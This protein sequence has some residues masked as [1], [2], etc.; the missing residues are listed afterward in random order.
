MSDACIERQV[1]TSR[2]FQADGKKCF[3]QNLL[4]ADLITVIMKT[5]QDLLSAER[6]SL[7]MV[8]KEKKEIWSTV[9]HG[10]GEI[11]LP[12]NKGIAGT[13]GVH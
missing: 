11:R 7:F 4:F 5:A 2:G 3:F 1:C 6:C 8:D 12:M 9:A 13:I 10:T